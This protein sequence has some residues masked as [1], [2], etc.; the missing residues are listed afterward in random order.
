MEE[1][2]FNQDNLDGTFG[3]RV[4]ITGEQK[5]GWF[6]NDGS[7]LHGYGKDETNEGCFEAGKLNRNM[8]DILQ[9]DVQV[10]MIAQ[11]ITFDSFI[12]PSLAVKGE[13]QDIVDN[14]QTK[15]KDYRIQ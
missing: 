8:Q 5:I 1:G 7:T 14:I 6:K 11:K 10:D 9:Y 15:I 2:E 12:L 13:I 3:R 4:L